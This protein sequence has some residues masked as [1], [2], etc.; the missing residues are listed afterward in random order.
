MEFRKQIL[1]TRSHKHTDDQGGR[2]RTNKIN[3][4]Q[5]Y[6]LIKNENPKISA[7]IPQNVE[8]TKLVNDK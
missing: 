5:N 6:K 4:Q 8:R 2:A 1:F 3:Q 7:V